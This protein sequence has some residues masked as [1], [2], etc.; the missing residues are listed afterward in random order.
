MMDAMGGDPEDRSAFE[1]ETAA[2]G[3]EVLDPLGGTIAAVREKAV[4]G[5]ADTH[6]DGEEVHDGEGGQILPGEEE[7]RGDGTDMEEA[8]SDGRDPVDA[9]LLILAAHAKVLLD[10]HLDFGDGG[11]DRGAGGN[12]LRGLY[13]FGGD[14]G[15][16]HVFSLSLELLISTLTAAGG[17]GCKT[18]VMLPNDGN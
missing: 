14:H 5:Y 2:H 10:L 18:F 4:I 3:D 11:D 12:V 8:H 16:A 7:E 15:R 1:R 17:R 9:T 13:F 6:V